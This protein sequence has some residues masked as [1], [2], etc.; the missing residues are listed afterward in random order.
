MAGRKHILYGVSPRVDLLPDAQRAELQ[1]ERTLPKLLLALVASAI[2]A[3]LIWAAG[4]IPVLLADDELRRVQTESDQLAAKL[5]GYGET[6][7]MLGWVKSRSADRQALTAREVLFIEVRDDIVSALPEG[8]SLVR[9]LG[10]LPSAETD[11]AGAIGMGE[12]CLATGATVLVTVSAA[13]Q[14]EALASA[15][16]LMDGVSEV[17]G[18]LCGLLVGSRVIENVDGSVTEVQ[19]RFVFDETVHAGRFAEGDEQ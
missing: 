2:V 7:R 1:H 6:Q 3:G 5:D 16:V 8:L 13:G 14:S 11:A 19:L 18:H 9:F 12:Q 4:M 10:E 15:A 17:E